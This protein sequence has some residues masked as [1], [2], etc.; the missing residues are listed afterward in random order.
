MNQYL[1]KN[2]NEHKIGQKLKNLNKKMGSKH[3]ITFNSKFGRETQYY[4]G[5]VFSICKQNKIKHAQ[6]K[7]R[8][9]F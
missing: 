5:L 1:L 7:L 4:T 2:C 9:E 3:K 8:F 6:I